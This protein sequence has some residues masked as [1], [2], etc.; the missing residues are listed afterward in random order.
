MTRSWRYARC[1]KRVRRS[2]RHS[3]RLSQI[4]RVPVRV[5]DD[6]LHHPPRPFTD[7]LDDG[8]LGLSE[9]IEDGG[10]ILYG[11][12]QVEVLTVTDEGNAWVGGVDEFQVE[13]EPADIYVCIEIAIEEQAVRPASYV[14]HSVGAVLST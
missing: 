8:H 9:A 1:L 12:V 6:E 3:L 14:G 13:S 11:E 5:L 10:K 4:D 7:V 2:Q